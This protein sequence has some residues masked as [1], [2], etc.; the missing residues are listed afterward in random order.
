MAALISATVALGTFEYVVA[1]GL[2]RATESPYPSYYF[3]PTL[4]PTESDESKDVLR[5]IR[6][7]ISFVIFITAVAIMIEAAVIFTRLRFV[8]INIT[9]LLSVV[10]L[11]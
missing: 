1:P 3:R 7:P 10:S 9:V 4:R 2:E 8:G 11:F 6:G 5:E